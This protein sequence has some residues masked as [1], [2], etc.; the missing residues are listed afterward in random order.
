M[1]KETISVVHALC[2]DKSSHCSMFGS[3]CGDFSLADVTMLDNVPTHQLS[4]DCQEYASISQLFAL[5]TKPLNIQSYIKSISYE[6]NIAHVYSLSITAAHAEP[7][8]DCSCSTHYISFV[9]R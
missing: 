2:F 9:R 3:V 4:A 6:H 8:G 1:G 5:A 7:S